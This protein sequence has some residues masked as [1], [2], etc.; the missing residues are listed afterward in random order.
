[1]LLCSSRCFQPVKGPSRGLLC[2][3]ENFADGSFTALVRHLVCPD[4]AAG[5]SPPTPRPVLYCTVL[6]CT[7]LYFTLLYCTVL[8]CAVLYCTVLCYTVLY[9]TCT[10]PLARVRQLRAPRRDAPTQTLTRLQQ[11]RSG[12]YK[13]S[14]ILTL[15]I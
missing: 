10:R 15:I 7:V 5:E 4:T 14:S 6:Y 12:F 11:Q 9:C 1:M 3:C 13:E 8:Y 2:D